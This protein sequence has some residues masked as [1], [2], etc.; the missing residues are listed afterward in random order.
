MAIHPSGAD[1][2]DVLGVIDGSV[3][4]TTR[5]FA[6]VLGENQVVQLDELV[7]TSQTLPDGTELH[8]YGIVTEGRNSIEGAEFASDTERITQGMTMPGL[9]SSSV[10]VSVLRTVPELWL[11]PKPGAAV[12]RASGAHRENALFL[13]QME[14]PLPIGVDQSGLPV[15]ADFSFINGEKGGH[16]SISGISGVATKTSFGLFF[17]YMLFETEAGRALL[18]KSGPLV[19]AVVFNV[20]GEDLLHI[21]RPN[22]RYESKA[23]A[24]EQWAALGV[25]KP[26]PFERVRLYAPRSQSST[27]GSLATDINSRDTGEVVAYAWTPQQFI[28]QGLLRYCL[29]EADDPRNQL[30]FVEQRVRIQ[31]ARWAYPLENEDGAVLLAPP[32][33]GSSFNMDRILQEKRPPRKADEGHPFRGFSDLIDFL[34]PLFAPEDG[35][36]D[37]HWAA[38]VQMGTALAFLRRLY[39]Q[40]PRIGHLVAVGASE[41]QLDEPV[42]V[43][44]IHSLHDDAQRFVVGALVSRIFEEKQGHGRE[45]LRFIVLDELNKY[46]PREGRSPIKELLVDVAARGRSLGVILVGAQ[47]SAATVEPTVVSNAAVSVIGRLA[48]GEAE[49]YKFLSPELRER[50]TRFLPGLMV[51]DQPLIP[52]PIPIRFPFPAFSTSTAEDTGVSKEVKAKQ[53]ADAFERLKK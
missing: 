40:A 45:P 6:I 35:A 25:D 39:A 28:R 50:A 33:D 24:P 23:G 11:P 14:Q 18:G 41:V 48:A 43:V 19:R 7:V 27:A 12:K 49:G 17:L 37:N 22:A 34:T 53:Q 1:E 30:S 38:G 47:Q 3:D 36:L 42:T 32:P 8:H 20:K 9:M 5:E 15:F 44:D 10:E 31:L 13:D 2:S 4:S 26:G 16:L 29:P 46:A 21:D 52:A 51:L